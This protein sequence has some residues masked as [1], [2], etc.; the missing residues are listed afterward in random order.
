MTTV[1]CMV[2]RG[3]LPI[4]IFWSLNSVPIV[5]G[6]QSFTITRIT[7]RTSA[8]TIE[9][10]DAIHRGNYSCIARNKAGFVEHST[11]L[12]V[13]GVYLYSYI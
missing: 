11:E 5:T 6:H 12:K 9:A 1:T 4:D 8:L 3:D 2:N 7:A 10:L 13:D